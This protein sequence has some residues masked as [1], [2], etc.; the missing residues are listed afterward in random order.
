MIRIE[1]SGFE[2]DGF[3]YPPLKLEIPENV[4]RIG[5]FG[6]NGSGKTTFFKILQKLEEVE[7]LSITVNENLVTRVDYIP[8]NFSVSNKF[9][10]T[11]DFILDTFRLN[12]ID[13]NLTDNKDVHDL[14]NK[15]LSVLSGGEMKRLLFWLSKQKCSEAILLDE[16]LANLDPKNESGILE[17]VS[18]LS[19]AD[20]N[21]LLFLSSHSKDH[22]SSFSDWLIGFK[23][24]EVKFSGNKEEFIKQNIFEELHEI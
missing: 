22:L 9:I 15:R 16:I 6:P 12:N 19:H 4:R 8:Q 18:N 21:R 7:R 24:C 10:L 3:Q 20:S 11:S 1:H 23:D 14:I 13:P 2:K 5:V 17:G